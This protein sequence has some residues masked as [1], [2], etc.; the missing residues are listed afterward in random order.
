MTRTIAPNVL[1]LMA[2][3]NGEK[4]LQEQ[5]D[6]IINQSAVEITIYCQDDGSTDKTLE[7]LRNNKVNVLENENN[8]GSSAQNFISLAWK[9]CMLPDI[10]EFEFV[11]FADQ[12]DIWLPNKISSAVDKLEHD[13]AQCYSS[14]FY[15]QRN[16]KLKISHKQFT[17]SE[18]SP[19]FRSPGP[20][21]TYVLTQKAFK[22]IFLDKHLQLTG[23]LEQKYFRWHDWL[24][25]AIASKKSLKW[26]FDINAY[27]VYR[28][29]ETNDTG[30]VSYKNFIGRVRFFFNGGYFKECKK[31]NEIVQNE[32]LT[33]LLERQSIKDKITL[34]KYYKYA[35]TSV[36]ERIIF[37]LACVIS[38]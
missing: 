37:I 1:I 9:A 2:T 3:Y 38:K 19:V 22:R 17:F 29:H 13:Q 34:A 4:Y 25:F 11:A 18:V 35:R 14:N 6:S 12:D 23:A 5:L 8:C 15:L 24:I 21:F 32:F 31:I 36:P 30:T 28:Q 26:T 20:G 7:I 27:A 10:E 16:S 33:Q